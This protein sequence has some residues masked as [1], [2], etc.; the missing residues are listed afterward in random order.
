MTDFSHFRSDD[1][2]TEGFA[3]FEHDSTDYHPESWAIGSDEIGNPI[4]CEAALS[5]F[6]QRDA[7]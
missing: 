2:I 7:L 3:G 5:D 1:D 4:Y 6:L